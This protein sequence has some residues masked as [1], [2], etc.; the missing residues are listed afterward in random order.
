MG[1]RAVRL[2]RMD[3]MEK[4]ATIGRPRECIRCRNCSKMFVRDF[5]INKRVCDSFCSKKCEGVYFKL[6]AKK[7][8]AGRKI[9][10]IE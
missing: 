10:R 5:V 9:K 2:D 1:D 4:G 8:F 7:I 6:L 3:H